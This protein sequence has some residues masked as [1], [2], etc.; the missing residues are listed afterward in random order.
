MDTEALASVR[1][2]A[3]VS[4]MPESTVTGVEAVL[5]PA[6]KAALPPLAETIGVW[7]VAATVTVRVT[8]LLLALPSL[9]WKLMVRVAVLG[10]MALSV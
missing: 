10:V 2:S 4:V 1:L 9:T 8:T 7:S 6:V 3:S 5:S